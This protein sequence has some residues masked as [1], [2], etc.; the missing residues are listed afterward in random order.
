MEE[1]QNHFHL[2]DTPPIVVQLSFKCHQWI[3]KFISFRMMYD[4]T[5]ELIDLDIDIDK[6]CDWRE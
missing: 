5:I 1:K 3:E 4:M 6:E 2:A